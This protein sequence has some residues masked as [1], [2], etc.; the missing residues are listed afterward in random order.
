VLRGALSG[1][2]RKAAKNRVKSVQKKS[3]L[4][5]HTGHFFRAHPRADSPIGTVRRHPKLT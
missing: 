4:G 5:Y 1:V 3:T 2:G